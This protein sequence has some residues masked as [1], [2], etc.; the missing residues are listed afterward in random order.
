[1]NLFKAHSVFLNILRIQLQNGSVLF[2][3]SLS[4]TDYKQISSVIILFYWHTILLSWKT[5]RKRENL[6]MHFHI[7]EHTLSHMVKCKQFSWEKRNI[8]FIPTFIMISAIDWFFFLHYCHLCPG[9]RHSL[10][11]VGWIPWSTSKQRWER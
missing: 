8:N 11:I 1:M 7:S 5:K 4:F 3:L 9:A 6:S 10:K 2:S